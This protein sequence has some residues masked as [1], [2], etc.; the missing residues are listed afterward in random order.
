[1]NVLGFSNK[2]PREWNVSKVHLGIGL[3]F[4]NDRQVEADFES[5]EGFVNHNVL[6]LC[7]RNEPRRGSRKIRRGRC[8]GLDSEASNNQE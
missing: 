8:R 3:A 5:L 6:D 4:D 7:G 1:M 2:S